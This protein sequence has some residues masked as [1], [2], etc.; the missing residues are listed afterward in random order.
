MVLVS[1]ITSTLKYRSDAVKEPLA[2][3]YVMLFG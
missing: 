2:T 3:S 1:I